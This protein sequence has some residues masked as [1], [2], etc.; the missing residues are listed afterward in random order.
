MHQEQNVAESIMNMCLD[1]TSF[2]KDNLNTRKDLADLCDRPNM[3]AKPNARGD[4][5]R[6]KASYCLKLTQRKEVLRWIKTLKFP[7]RYATN[8]KRAVNVDT[9]KLNGLKSHDYHIFIERL[10]PVMFC[11]YF[12]PDLWKMFAELSYF[13]IQ[14]CAK[15][16]SKAMMQMLEKEIAVLVCKIETVFLPG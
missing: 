8:I 7:D 13:Y 6:T 14:I 11:R 9:G 16:V 4:L 3:D 5:R 12:K 1:V 10:M 15:Q 2:M